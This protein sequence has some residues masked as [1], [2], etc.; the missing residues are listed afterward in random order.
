MKK[1]LSALAL[2]LAIGSAQAADIN[3]VLTAEQAKNYTLT[4]GPGSLATITLPDPARNV[5]VTRSGMIDTTTSEN[6]IIVAGISSTGNVPMQFSTENGLWTWRVKLSSANA[7]SIVNVTVLPPEEEQVGGATTPQSAAKPTAQTANT[8]PG[9]NP[10]PQLNLNLNPVRTVPTPT[11]ANDLLTLTA[12]D[13]PNARFTLQRDGDVVVLNYRVQAGARGLS[14]D[15]RN[16]KLKSADVSGLVRPN[17]SSMIFG[18]GE[19]RYGSVMVSGLKA[20]TTAQLSWPYRVGS[21]TQTL[22]QNVVIP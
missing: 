1:L 21:V 12:A 17:L 19:V 18:A 5:I 2:T 4:L 9:T 10:E 11:T 8:A 16:L 14:L 15:E 20:G 13:G 22:T 7:G 6:H 3:V